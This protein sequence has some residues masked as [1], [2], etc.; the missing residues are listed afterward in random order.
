MDRNRKR[1]K[2]IFEAFSLV[3]NNYVMKVWDYTELFRKSAVNTIY[4]WIHEM[5]VTGLIDKRS[6]SV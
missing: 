5:V 1:G 4:G 3:I 6:V 2:R